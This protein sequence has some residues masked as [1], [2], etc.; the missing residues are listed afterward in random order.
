MA[1][2][3]ERPAVYCEKC[4]RESAHIIKQTE[5]DGTTHDVCWKC[6]SRTEKRFNLKETWKRGGRAR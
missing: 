4:G 6:V 2:T 3:E 1:A 5:P